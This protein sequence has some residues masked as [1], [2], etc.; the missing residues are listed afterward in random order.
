MQHGGTHQYSDALLGYSMACSASSGGQK[1]QCFEIA[2]SFPAELFNEKYQKLVTFLQ[3]FAR[4]CI[5]ELV[6]YLNN[7]SQH[8]K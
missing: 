5:Q 8:F 7:T 6:D 4:I 3:F 1:T 2:M